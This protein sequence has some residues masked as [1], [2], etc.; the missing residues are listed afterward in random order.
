MRSTNPRKSRKPKEQ[1]N[2][3]NRGRT[4]VK[5]LLTDPEEDNDRGA[6]FPAH[7]IVELLNVY[8]YSARENK[9]AAPTA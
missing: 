4:S 3:R 5:E 7:F 9:V 2:H 8:I 6:Y 1:K